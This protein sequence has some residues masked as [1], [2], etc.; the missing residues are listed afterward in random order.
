MVGMQFKHMRILRNVQCLVESTNFLPLNYLP[1]IFARTLED[2]L[3]VYLSVFKMRGKFRLE[4]PTQ[5]GGWSTNRGEGW[6][7]KV[8]IDAKCMETQI[9]PKTLRPGGRVYNWSA[10]INLFRG[11]WVGMKQIWKSWVTKYKLAKKPLDWEWL[12][13]LDGPR[14]FK[15]ICIAASHKIIDVDENNEV[16]DKWHWTEDL[17]L[18]MSVFLKWWCPYMIYYCIFLP[19][20]IFVQEDHPCLRGRL[21]NLRSCSHVSYLGIV[22][23]L[24]NC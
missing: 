24:S 13:W 2:D 21:P 5:P 16:N 1:Q 23:I 9:F 3:G 14:G 15:M 20:V 4:T 7:S 10:E 11:L 17:E 22:M 12:I 6:R 19:R 8:S 18:Y